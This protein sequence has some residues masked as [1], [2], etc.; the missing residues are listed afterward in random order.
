MLLR[1]IVQ[2]IGLGKHVIYVTYIIP[3]NRSLS[4]CQVENYTMNI[5]SVMKK[6][7]VKSAFYVGLFQYDRGKLSY[8]QGVR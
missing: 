6:V 3:T 4:T 7:K 5:V 8:Y 2:F 1:Q